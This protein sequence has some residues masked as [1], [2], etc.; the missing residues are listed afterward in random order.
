M[1]TISSL[2]NFQS[3]PSL[4]LDAP[5]THTNFGI[6]KQPPKNRTRLLARSKVY[7]KTVPLS[8]LGLM[9]R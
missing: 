1:Q 4:S 8:N 2:L 7:Q 6:L 9:T 3:H 5:N